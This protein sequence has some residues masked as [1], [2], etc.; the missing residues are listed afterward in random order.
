INFSD[1]SDETDADFSD[2]TAEQTAER[3]VCTRCL[4]FSKQNRNQCSSCDAW[5]SMI[6]APVDVIHKWSKL[7]SVELPDA[8]KAY[9][10]K[11][12]KPAQKDAPN[13]WDFEFHQWDKCDPA[14][15]EPRNWIYGKHYLAGAVSATIADGAVGKSIL[16]L[17]EAIAIVTGRPLLGV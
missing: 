16:E 11:R 2:E 6:C 17:T 5:N 8:I 15:I 9:R 10:Q 12:P 14:K 1:F 3:Y 7:D 13:I 4:A